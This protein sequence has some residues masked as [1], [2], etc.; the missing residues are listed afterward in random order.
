VAILPAVARPG[1]TERYASY[2]TGGRI[3]RIEIESTGN[4]NVAAP[5]LISSTD[6]VFGWMG[7]SHTFL[8]D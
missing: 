2:G 1:Q 4:V 5:N 6:E 7:L 3:G 8:T